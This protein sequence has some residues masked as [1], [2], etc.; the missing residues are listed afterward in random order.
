MLGKKIW[1]LPICI[2]LLA[3]SS[4]GIPGVQNQGSCR[5]ID[6]TPICCTGRTNCMGVNRVSHYNYIY[7]RS[8]GYK[9]DA[10]NVHH[11]VHAANCFCD[12]YCV[13]TNDCCWDYRDICSKPSWLSAFFVK[14]ATV[15]L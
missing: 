12:E 9:T 14:F 15:A 2:L 8:G 6:G 11:A 13:N 1:S 7:T 5:K 4:N 10:G 3:T